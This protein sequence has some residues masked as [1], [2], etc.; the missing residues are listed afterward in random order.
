MKKM[1]IAIFLTSFTFFSVKS[2][3]L[4][5]YNKGIYFLNISETDSVPYIDSL[6]ILLI[7][8]HANNISLFKE[9]ME[10]NPQIIEVQMKNPP[11][12][13]IEI[14]SK[15]NSKN[16]TYLFIHEYKG[17]NLE[18]PKFSNIILF[19]IESEELQN[20]SMLNSRFDSLRILA[21]D[22]LN[23]SIWTTDSVFPSLGLIDLKTINLPAFPIT[24]MPK[25]RQFTFDC[26]FDEIPKY[27]CDCKDL[28]HISFQNYKFIEID[29]CFNKKIKTSVY[30]NITIF[31]SKNG[32]KVLEILSDIR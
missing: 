16:L 26:S 27:L 20:L 15:L 24:V 12:E 8:F 9:A 30:S 25:I 5:P 7:E 17:L 19:L 1:L 21:I 22:V 10:N 2:Q 14:L 28:T 11:R 29:K 4:K 32:K 13:A 3:N 6:K 23:L 18:V 31:E